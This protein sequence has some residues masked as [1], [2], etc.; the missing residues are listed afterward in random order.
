MMPFRGSTML[1]NLL[2]KLETAGAYWE[3]F[4]G[5]FSLKNSHSIFN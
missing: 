3:E 4:N 1:V 5:Y 2:Q